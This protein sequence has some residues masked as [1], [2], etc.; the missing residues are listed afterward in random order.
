MSIYVGFKRGEL[1]AGELLANLFFSQLMDLNTRELP[2]GNPPLKYQCALILDEFA[3]P[4]KI[5]IIDT[6]TPFIAGYNLR[7]ML[8]LLGMSQLEDLKLYSKHGAETLAI[9][10]KMRSLCAPR[11]IR[12][13]EE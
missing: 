6:A 11:T 7:L 9:N 5:E 13:S 3:V 2:A 12:E 10:G 1:K 8:I 4:G